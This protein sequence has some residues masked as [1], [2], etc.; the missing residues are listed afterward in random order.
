MASAVVSFVVIGV[1]ELCFLLQQVY[2]VASAVVAFVVIGVVE[3]LVDLAVIV[4][5]KSLYFDGH[6]DF[7]L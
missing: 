4:A 5:V 6:Q 7:V 2:L 3:V 1:V